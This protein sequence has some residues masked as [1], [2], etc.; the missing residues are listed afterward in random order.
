MTFVCWLAVC[1]R[2][3]ERSHGH[4]NLPGDQVRVGLHLL[5]GGA[6]VQLVMRSDSLCFVR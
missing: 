5:V 2:A 6:T 4:V 1:S 3:I